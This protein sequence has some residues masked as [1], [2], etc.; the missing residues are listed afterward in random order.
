[1]NA[2]QCPTMRA[3]MNGVHAHHDVAHCSRVIAMQSIVR[4]AVK[5]SKLAVNRSRYH[6]SVLIVSC[7]GERQGPSLSRGLVGRD[8]IVQAVVAFNREVR[9]EQRIRLFVNNTC[10]SGLL[11]EQLSESVDFVIGHGLSEIGDDEAIIFTKTLFDALGQGLSLHA[12]FLSASMVSNPFRLYA[13]RC[14]PASFFLCSSTVDARNYNELMRF[15]D[16][17]G[18]QS[19]AEKFCVAMGG[20]ELLEDFKSLKEEDFND[21]NLHFL[22][23]WQ[24]RKL[25]GLTARSTAL[26]VSSRDGYDSDSLSCSAVDGFS[27]DGGSDG[28]EVVAMKYRGDHENFQRHMGG[29]IHDFLGYMTVDATAD[30]EWETYDINIKGQGNRKWTWCMLLWIRFVHDSLR[31]EVGCRMWLDACNDDPNEDKLLSTFNEILNLCRLGRDDFEGLECR[32]QHAAGIFVT[33][34]M[35]CDHLRGN[36][37]EKLQWEKQVERSWFYD[38]EPPSNFLLRANRFLREHMTHS[39]SILQGGRNWGRFRV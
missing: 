12:S 38:D 9:P 36:P 5:S 19:I 11:A 30:P 20:M 3:A 32:K 28:G 26:A 6:P 39:I 15:L 34:M 27:V 25:L 13:R 22:Q 8:S 24:K 33:S 4:A 14:S 29:F 7:H 2:V 16:D 17:Q 1:M 31:D 37:D 10:M 18:L 35:V 23:P 21:T